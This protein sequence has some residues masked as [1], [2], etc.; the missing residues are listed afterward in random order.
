MSSPFVIQNTTFDPGEQ[1][2]AHLTV[3]RLPSDTRIQ[4]NIHVYRST[5]PGPTLLVMAGVHGDEINGVE[6]VRRTIAHGYFEQLQRGSVIA[7]PLL[8]VYG[9]INFSREVPDGKDVNR[10]FPGNLK[11]SLASRVARTLTKKVLPLIDFGVDFHTG[12]RNHYNFPQV[13]YTKNDPK[14]G[15]LAAQF[16]APFTLGKSPLAKS[17]RKVARDAGKP[18]LVYEGG[19]NQ[20]FD[21]FSIEKGLAGLRRVLAAQD[22]IA[23]KV[24]P[25]DTLYFTQTTWIRAAR[26][27]LFRWS[28]RSGHAIRRGEPLGVINDPYGMDEIPVVAPRDGYIVGHNNAPVVSTGD[29]LFHVAY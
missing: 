22:M 16:A 20:R 19:E 29:A 9:F 24:E 25:E 27:G 26:A 21:G 6:I 14:A 4:I 10:S 8:N 7:I 5:E 3:G 15:E 18:I 28:K 17:L 12:G 2:I 11:G 23:E 1:G 13:R